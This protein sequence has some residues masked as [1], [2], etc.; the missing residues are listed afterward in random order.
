MSKALFVSLLATLILASV[1]LAQAQQAKIY[2]VGVI[3][4]GGPFYTAI[5]G[6]KDGLRESGFEEGKQYLLEI[7]DVKG[8]PKAIEG[9]ARSLEHEKVNLIYALGTS[10]ST[11]VKRATTEVP[12]VFAGGND[13]VTA[14]LIESFARPWG[15]HHG[16][17]LFGG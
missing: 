13:P 9:A 15:A 8:D 6:L 4:Q 3:L 10:V 12:I 5:D 7:R 16:R 1:H 2:R 17:P 14:G 11:A